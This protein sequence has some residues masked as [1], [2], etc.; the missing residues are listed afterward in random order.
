MRR[1]A[2]NE[3]V[4]FLA[5]PG[6]ALISW[7]LLP[8][9]VWGLDG[10]RWVAIIGAS[11]AVFVWFIRRAIPESPRW[12]EQHGRTEEA[13]RVMDD[14]EARVCAET[15]RELPPVELVEGETEQAAG[16]WMEMWRQ[17]YRSRTILLI[18]FQVLQ[19]VGY[20]G[21]ASWV[22]TFLISQGIAVTKSLQYTFLMAI[23]SPLG[24]LLGRALRISLSAS[25]RSPGRPS[26]S[27][28]ADCYS[29]GNAARSAWSSLVC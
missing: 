23:A 21:F 9:H 7:L 20:Y 27:P 15:G 13:A 18:V 5:V 28:R 6:G 29:R 10:W 17:P 2:F 26:S 14:I 11:G 1:F 8:L 16:S 22:P 19:A 3:F 12:L 4:S 24:P 25:G